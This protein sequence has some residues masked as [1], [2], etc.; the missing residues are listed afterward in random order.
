MND[1]QN[2]VYSYNG[3]LFDNKNERNAD[4]CYY[5]DIIS[6]KHYAQWKNP[7]TKHPILHGIIYRNCLE[8][9]NIELYKVDLWF[10]W[11]VG[12]GRMRGGKKPGEEMGTD[13]QRAEFLYGVI[14]MF[15]IFVVLM[16]T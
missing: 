4:T 5:M 8:K 14:V 11:L 13:S 15:K 6:L 1:T 2:V 12:R 10:P 7:V 3:I 9:E 16:T